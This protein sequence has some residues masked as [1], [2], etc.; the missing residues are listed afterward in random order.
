MADGPAGGGLQR[1]DTAQLGEGGLVAKPAG[2]VAG[3]YQQR[4]GDLD[5]DA[6]QV[7]QP[8][9]ARVTGQL[10]ATE[11]VSRQLPQAKRATADPG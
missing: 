11:A 2:V 6:E 4:A 1:C 7:Q 9:A 3:G 5:P 8:W 10:L